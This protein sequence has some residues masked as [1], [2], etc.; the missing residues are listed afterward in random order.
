VKLIWASLSH[1]IFWVDAARDCSQNGIVCAP[2]IR[3]S[4][5]S[6]FDCHLTLSLDEISI[7]LRGITGLETS[8]ILSQSAIEGV[9]DHCHDDVE[10]D[11]DEDG[12]GECVE[13]EEFHRLGDAILHTPP[14]GIVSDNEFHRVS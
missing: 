13:M 11:L 3:D 6:A 4:Y 10:M 12:R 2:G 14:T 9:C 8:E 5:V 1:G 7:Q